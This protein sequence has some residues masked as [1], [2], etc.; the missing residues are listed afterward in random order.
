[1]TFVVA[2]FFGTFFIG[3]LYL[4]RVLGFDALAIGLGFLPISLCIG[5]ISFAFAEPLITRFGPLRVLRTGLALVLI[6]MLWLARLPV[7][8]TYALDV[9][10]AL[11]LMGVG[12]GLVFPATVGMAMSGATSTDAGLTSGLVNTTRMV[13]G[14]LGIAVMASLASARVATLTVSGAD[15]ATAVTVGSQL[16]M[17]FGAAMVGAA[18]VVAWTV[19]RT[20][21]AVAAVTTGDSALET[22]AWPDA[23]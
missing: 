2:G 17:T 15:P 23:A 7:E 4:E 19:L 8:A 6:A 11:F 21:R 9:A 14:S 18:I 10:P 12:A 13:G 1:M 20:P 5:L 3:S 22:E 16:A